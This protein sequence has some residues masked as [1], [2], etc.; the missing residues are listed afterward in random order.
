[1]FI[2]QANANMVITIHM[3]WPG[4]AWPGMAWYGMAWYSMAWQTPTAN[5]Q[6]VQ[7]HRVESLL[8]ALT[9]ELTCQYSL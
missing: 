1:M 4:L 3:E 2:K 9:K 5:L 6:I 8:D 7:I